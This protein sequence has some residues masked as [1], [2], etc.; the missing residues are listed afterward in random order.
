MEDV[1]P[2]GAVAVEAEAA[3]VEVGGMAEVG[4]AVAGTSADVGVPVSDVGVPVAGGS[5]MVE[6]APPRAAKNVATV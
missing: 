1:E 2:V 4:V 6:T 3:T 5:A